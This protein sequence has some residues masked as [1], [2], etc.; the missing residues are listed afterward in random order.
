MYITKLGLSS[1]GCRRELVIEGAFDIAGFVQDK[2]KKNKNDTPRASELLKLKFKFRAR[3]ASAE[4]GKR[5][6]ASR[7]AAAPSLSST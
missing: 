3:A 1:P 5:W 2:F 4:S 7:Q 6:A